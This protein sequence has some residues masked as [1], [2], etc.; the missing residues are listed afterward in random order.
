MPAPVWVQKLFST[1]G[2]LCALGWLLASLGAQQQP[3]VREVKILPPKPCPDLLRKVF[4]WCTGSGVPSLSSDLLI[5]LTPDVSRIAVL[6]TI[7]VS[8]FHFNTTK[9]WGLAGFTSLLPSSN[10]APKSLS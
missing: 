2:A 5:G 4:L 10:H 6:Q 1:A 8:G 7:A 3:C 9:G